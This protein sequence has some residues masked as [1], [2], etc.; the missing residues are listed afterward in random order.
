MR[1]PLPC[2]LLFTV[3]PVYAETIA[4][5]GTGD[6]AGALGPEFAAQGHTIIYGSREPSRSSVQELIGRTGSGTTA[7]SPYAAATRADVVVLAVPGVLVAEITRNLGDLADKIVIDPTNPIERKLL[8]MTHA[9]DTSN[10]EI[11][12]AIAPDAHVVKAFNTLGWKIMI[13]PRDAGGPVSVPLAGDSGRAK[14]FVSEL[15]E[16]ME[17]EPIDVGP[18]EHARWLEGMAI[19]LINNNYMSLRP[20]FNFHLRK[21]D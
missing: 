20:A 2:L 13:D 18:A 16:G 10:T 15:I 9:A 1:Y 8:T 19:L 3:L 7:T 21:T 12:Q 4:I 6:V 11:I 5:I 17:L 14:D